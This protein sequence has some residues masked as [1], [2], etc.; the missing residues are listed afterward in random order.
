MVRRYSW[1]C[2]T[3]NYMPVRGITGLSGRCRFANYVGLEGFFRLAMIY[4]KEEKILRI[5]ERQ[6][7][8]YIIIPAYCLGG[9]TLAVLLSYA[10]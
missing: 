5:G 6:A 1:A 7:S 2:L 3:T 10:L 8:K 9:R 4:S